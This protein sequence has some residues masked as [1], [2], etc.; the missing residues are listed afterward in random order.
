MDTKNLVH[1]LFLFFQWYK[2]FIGKVTIIFVRTVAVWLPLYKGVVEIDISTPFSFKNPAALRT[3]ILLISVLKFSL[4][5][6]FYRSNSLY[7]KYNTIL[8]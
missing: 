4:F 2:S 3:Y 8:I 7:Y 6:I 5:D 1:V